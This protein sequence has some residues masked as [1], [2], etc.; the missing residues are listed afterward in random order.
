MQ[1]F[2][3]ETQTSSNTQK[4][5]AMDA[6][7]SQLLEIREQARANKDFATSDKI[8][9]QLQAAGI[10]IKDYRDKASEWSFSDV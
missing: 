4:L 9:D 1:R 3:L 7:V 8:R 5:E 10:S 6:I 2:N